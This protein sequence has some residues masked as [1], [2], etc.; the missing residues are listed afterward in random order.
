MSQSQAPQARGCVF[1]LGMIITAST[2]GSMAGSA[3]GRVVV[4]GAY[5]VLGLVEAI[6]ETMQDQRR[7]GD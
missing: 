6:G 1:V 5:L 7:K 2:V 3:G 4:G